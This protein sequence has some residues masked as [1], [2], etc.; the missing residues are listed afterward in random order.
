[1]CD[2]HSRFTIPWK[3]IWFTFDMTLITCC[4]IIN[5]SFTYT[6]PYTWTYCSL[7][8]MISRNRELRSDSVNRSEFHDAI[9]AIDCN[10]A[11]KIGNIFSL[12]NVRHSPWK[13]PTANRYS[14]RQSLSRLD[15][16]SRD[17]QG[18]YNYIEIKLVIKMFKKLFINFKF[19]ADYNF[20]VAFKNS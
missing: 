14:W 8:L 16:S 9:M 15:T 18:E 4:Y 13:S 12:C 17:F 2:T 6:I 11:E 3:I 5:F 10:F 19:V 20:N 7:Y 1:M